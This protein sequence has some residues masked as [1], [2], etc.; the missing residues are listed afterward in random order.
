[1]DLSTEKL[2]GTLDVFKQFKAMV[3]TQFNFPIKVEQSDLGG[4]F[5]P[6]TKFLSDLGIQH[7][8]ICPHTHHHNG[9]IERNHRVDMGLTLLFQVAM[10]LHYWDQAFLTAIYLINKLPSTSIQNEVPFQKMF[11]KTPN[12]SF[13]R[14]FGCACFHLLRPYNN[15]KLQYRSQEYV[16]LGYSYTKVTN[17]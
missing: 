9:V 14:I 1:M 2:V 16:F 17:V 4:E 6:F 8:L 7:R 11:H 3:N 12:Y 13:L 5:R 15:H 10:P